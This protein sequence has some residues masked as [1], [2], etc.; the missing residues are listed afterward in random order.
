MIGGSPVTNTQIK[1]AVAE[2]R[3]LDQSLAFVI[4]ELF[5]QAEMY[6]FDTQ[7]NEVDLFDMPD[8]ELPGMWERADF[9]GGETDTP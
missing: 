4:G 2:V 8:A 6:G 3:K 1:Q 5:N 9:T 7:R